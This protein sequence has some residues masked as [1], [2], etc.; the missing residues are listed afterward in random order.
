MT[1]RTIVVI[2][3]DP[4]LRLVTT[5]MLEAAG[6]AVAAFEDGDHALDHIR[7]HRQA[8]GG[9]FT[10]VRLTTETSGFEIAHLVTETFPDIAVVVTSGQFVD[11]P[12][13][14]PEN[15][16]YLAKP[17]LALEV[18]NAMIDATQDD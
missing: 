7:H 1:L 14:L 3:D 4:V 6:L 12:A 15:V 11:R 16:R 5:E 2:E 8:I 10:D 18:I 9:V 13:G 17:W